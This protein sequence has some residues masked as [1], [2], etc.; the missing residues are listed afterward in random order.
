MYKA[1][2][3]P[4]RHCNK[5]FV[6]S[7]LKAHEERCLDQQEKAK[8]PK[9]KTGRPIGIPAWNKGLT[10]ETDERVANNSKS[11]SEALRKMVEEGS[12][13]KRSMGPEARK[14]LSEEQS[15]RNR[16]GRSKWH[17]VGGVQVQG[18]YEKQFAEALNNQNVVWEKVKTNNHIFK[19]EMDDK[20]RSYA[21]DFYLPE[22]DLYVEIKGFWWGNDE[23]KMECVKTQHSDKNLVVIF[24]IDEL[25]RICEDIKG[26]LPLEPVWSWRRFESP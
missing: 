12:Y 2:Y 1:T 26:V 8:L 18:T 20:I 15:L 14:R 3:K 25:N 9:R 6:T 21:P 4:C 22:Y 5:E 24:G 10:N 17:D 16:G 11:A 13:I 19:Y 7:R 23:A